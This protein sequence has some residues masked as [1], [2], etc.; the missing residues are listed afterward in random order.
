M[1]LSNILY[2]LKG[3]KTFQNENIIGEVRLKFGN[4]LSST[5]SYCFSIWQGES[6]ITSSKTNLDFFCPPKVTIISWNLRV[7]WPR[8]TRAIPLH[9]EHIDGNQVRIFSSNTRLWLI[10]IDIQ[11]K[12][13]VLWQFKWG[14]FFVSSHYPQNHWPS[15][16]SWL[17]TGRK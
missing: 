15:I 4:K 1:G 16:T 6:W 7:S 10:K 17:H 12:K 11:W 2:S 3:K 8:L 5:V 13:I 9:K 14:I